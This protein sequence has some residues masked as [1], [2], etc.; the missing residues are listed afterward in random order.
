MAGDSVIYRLDGPGGN[1]GN[2]PEKIEFNL[3]LVPDATG[4]NVNSFWDAKRDVSIHPNPNKNLS[5]IQDGKLGT[6]EVTIAGYFVDPPGTG[7]KGLLFSWSTESADNDDYPFGR[8]GIRIDDLA[9]V[10]LNPDQTRGYIL[11]DV[12]CE[13]VEDSPDEVMFIAKLY[14][15]GV[16]LT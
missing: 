14:R 4:R 2:A 6:I 12:H 16:D 15:N 3:G 1:E 11:H 13:R 8:F 9:E 7:G 5:I 10:N